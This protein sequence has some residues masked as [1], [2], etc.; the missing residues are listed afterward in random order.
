MKQINLVGIDVSAKELTVKME[1]AG[2]ESQATFEN[3]SSGHKKLLKYITKGCKEALVCMEAT[4]I[5]HF[6]LALFLSNATKVKV[7]VINPKAIKHFAIALMKRGKT[8][9]LDA[10]VILEYIKRMEFK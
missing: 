5:Y 8:D 1:K 6:Q 3:G 9:P 7:M 2:R 10:S 4:G